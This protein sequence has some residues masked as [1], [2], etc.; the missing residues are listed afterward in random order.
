MSIS[1]DE[2]R[3]RPVP[4]PS[5]QAPVPINAPIT[6]QQQDNTSSTRIYAASP[7]DAYMSYQRIRNTPSSADRRASLNSIG[8]DSTCLSDDRHTSSTSS[9]PVSPPHQSYDKPV[10]FPRPTCIISERNTPSY[11]TMPSPPWTKQSLSPHN[12]HTIRLPPLSQLICPHN[13]HY[14][15]TNGG[16]QVDAAVAMMQLSQHTQQRTW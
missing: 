11:P 10:E 9:T 16:E 4:T 7:T 13:D 14:Q 1:S 5:P 12:K 2:Y 8:T 3:S 6:V 15:N